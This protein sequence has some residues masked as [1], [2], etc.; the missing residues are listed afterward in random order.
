MFLGRG[1]KRKRMAKNPYLL[2]LIH[3]LVRKELPTSEIHKILGLRVNVR[4]T[5]R[6]NKGQPMRLQT[7]YYH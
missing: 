5:R 4:K 6:K 1:R 7:I 2:D 3:A